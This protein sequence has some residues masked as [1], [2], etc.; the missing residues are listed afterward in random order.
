MK[1]KVD[2]IL[3]FLMYVRHII[4]CDGSRAW[5]TSQFNAF[6]ISLCIGRLVAFDVFAEDEENDFKI[7]ENWFSFS[8]Q[9]RT[10]SNDVLL[11]FV[12]WSWWP[13]FENWTRVKVKLSKSFEKQLRNRNAPFFSYLYQIFLLVHFH[14]QRSLSFTLWA[15]TKRT[16]FL[17][18]SDFLDKIFPFLF[19]L[20]LHFNE[21]SFRFISFE[22]FLNMRLLLQPSQPCR[23]H[24]EPRLA[25]EG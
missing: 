9:F 25:R 19:N 16:L 13:S 10:L 5:K 1:P 4:D 18:A 14:F 22:L 17:S 7:I 2:W 21:N 11:S 23:F 8:S 6:L 20:S 15:L 24:R 3:C 12:L